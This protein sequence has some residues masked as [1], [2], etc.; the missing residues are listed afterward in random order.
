MEIL[1]LSGLL[2]EGEERGDRKN[3]AKS[4]GRGDC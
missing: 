2:V 3:N 1:G 4:S